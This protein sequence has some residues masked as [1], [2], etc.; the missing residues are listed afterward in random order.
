VTTPATAAPYRVLLDRLEASRVRLS[1][2]ARRTETPEVLLS[3]SGMASAYLHAIA[4]TIFA[5]EGADAA[6]AY[7]QQAATVE[8]AMQP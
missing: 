8:A 6:Q 1:E 2:S 4:D 3:T 7:I 5:F